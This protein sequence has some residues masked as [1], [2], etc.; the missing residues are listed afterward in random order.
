[1]ASTEPQGVSEVSSWK[2]GRQGVLLTVPSGQRCKARR[3]GLDV[4]LRNGTVPNT[5]MPIIR[6]SMSTGD[7]DFKVDDFTPEM[8]EDLI[9]MV[10][11]IVMEAVVEPVLQ[12]PPA[13]AAERSD[14]IIYTD[15]VDL[16]DRM[17]IFN[18][19][20]GGSSDLEKFRKEQAA[21]VDNLRPGADVELPSES[22]VGD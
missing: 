15:D 19:V 8:L 12:R 17:F 2:K 5:L 4:F 16:D 3:I 20:V 18:W 9:T 11:N 1:M 21:A 13:T 10:D 22:V 14:D 6:E 7:T